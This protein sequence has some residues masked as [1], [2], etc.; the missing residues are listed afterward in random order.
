MIGRNSIL[1]PSNVD[2]EVIP[3]T[4]NGDNDLDVMW[5][6]G[7]AP[8]GHTSFS[9]SNDKS[10]DAIR[11]AKKLKARYLTL[12]VG[13]ESSSAA[14]IPLTLPSSTTSTTYGSVSAVGSGGFANGTYSGTTT[15]SGTKTTYIPITINRFQ[16]TAVYWAEVPKKGVGILTRELTPEEFTR[17]ETRRAWVV[18]SVRDKSPAY[19]ADI[20]P[21][22]I[23]AQV[24]GLPVD[25]DTWWAEIKTGKPLQ[26]KVMR[27]WQE[28]EMKLEVPPEW[29]P[30]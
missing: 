2:P 24:N 25:A 7:F 22:D 4:G 5:Q 18:R 29:Q 17:L 21:G 8:L 9:T 10:K 28:R 12:G 26:L 27:N 15:T 1:L 23:I 20:L 30:Q 3:S 6:R 13:L 11:L 16:K 14:S 19:Y